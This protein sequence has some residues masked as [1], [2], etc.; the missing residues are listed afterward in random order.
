[1]LGVA[2]WQG[3]QSLEVKDLNMIVTVAL[4]DIKTFIQYFRMQTCRGVSSILKDYM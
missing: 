1:M 4:V 3:V 2:L